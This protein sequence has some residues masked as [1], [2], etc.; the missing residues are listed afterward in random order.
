MTILGVLALV[1]Y[2]WCAV[3]CTRSF[4]VSYKQDAIHIS[5]GIPAW[6]A[7]EINTRSIFFRLQAHKL[8]RRL[9]D[10]DISLLKPDDVNE[11]RFIP[12]TLRD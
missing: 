8:S 5:H 6:A 3:Y 12:C 4:E 9:H 11:V 7:C 2:A 10:I 1:W